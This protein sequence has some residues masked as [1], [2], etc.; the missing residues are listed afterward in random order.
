MSDEE[1]D[2]FESMA[3]REGDP[4]EALGGPDDADEARPDDDIEETPSTPESSTGSEAG[5]AFEEEFIDEEP[6]G[7]G[8][9]SGSA[10]HSADDPDAFDSGPD[11]FG[12]MEEGGEDPFRDM[13]AGEGD[14]FGG[15]ESAFAAVDI[16][17]LDDE[18]LWASIGSND[19]SP[20]EHKRYSEVS[21][22]RFCEQCE[23]FAEP[24]AAHCTHEE[25]NILEFLDME[26]VRV[27]NCPIV[28]EQQRIEDEE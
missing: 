26:Q 7:A 25:A 27:V 2:P 21:K 23:F 1:D 15:A 8:A 12:E 11:P 14:P 6:F 24:P 10:D 13:S 22:H 19:T 20:A 9:E 4:F 17:A 18:E 16:E 5:P 3:D 28:A